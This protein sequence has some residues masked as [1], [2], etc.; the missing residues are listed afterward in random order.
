MLKFGTQ[1]CH[2]K[3]LSFWKFQLHRRL[4]WPITLKNFVKHIPSL[5]HPIDLKFGMVVDIINIYYQKNF[6]NFSAKFEF[7]E[8]Y[9]KLC[10][11]KKID[12]SALLEPIF[13]KFGGM[14]DITKTYHQNFF[15][16]FCTKFEVLDQKNW[17]IRL[18][19]LI[20]S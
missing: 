16:I 15:Q 6:R 20:I 17:H 19:L 18:I 10:F 14:I 1:F 2:E 8:L 12:F 11:Q 5:F 7:L 13:M 4:L 9:K 3:I